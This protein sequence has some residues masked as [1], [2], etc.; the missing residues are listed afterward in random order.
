[1][2]RT[3]FPRFGRLNLGPQD[4]LTCAQFF[5]GEIHY[6]LTAELFSNH[7][8]LILR[9]ETL[10]ENSTRV[11][12]YFQMTVQIEHGLDNSPPEISFASLNFLD[13]QN[14]VLKS[15]TREVLSAEDKDGAA[16]D[17]VYHVTQAP[18]LEDGFLVRLDEPTFPIESFTQRDVNLLKIA[19]RPPTSDGPKDRVI[20]SLILEIVDVEGLISEPVP[21][22]L[23]IK[24]ASY[25]APFVI[26]N[27]GILLLSGETKK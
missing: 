2:T 10:D 23:V 8:L 5:S 16:E 12:E 19:F 20:E 3:V 18:A 21:L 25:S 7:D 14:F 4:T 13:V 1:M 11:S 27:K 22:V 17:L 6:K 15:V 9:A 26:F 24:P